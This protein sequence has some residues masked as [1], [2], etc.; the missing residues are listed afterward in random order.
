MALPRLTGALRSFSNVTKHDDCSEELG[1]LTTKR[2]KLQEQ[3]LTSDLTW[4]KIIKFVDDNLDKKE[5][6]TVNG[7]LKTILQAAKQIVG[8]GLSGEEQRKEG[9]QLLGGWSER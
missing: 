2:S 7:D 6:Q 1:D 8:E 5:H 3:L 4:K 9:E